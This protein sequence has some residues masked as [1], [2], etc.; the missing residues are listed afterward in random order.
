MTD[1]DRKK[2]KDQQ[3]GEFVPTA[4][5]A[6]ASN[7]VTELH[8]RTFCT[9][10]PYAANDTAAWTK[11]L[12]HTVREVRVRACKVDTTTTIASDNTDYVKFTLTSQYPNG[13][14]I[15]THGAYN[16]HGGAQGALTANVSGSFSLNAAV[17]VV[18]ADAKFR[19]AQ[20]IGGAGKNVV[21]TDTA[22]TLD[23]EE[24]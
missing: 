12:A 16:T 20:S 7:E 13:D 10:R 3:I 19:I 24:I 21:V 4:G 9:S 5:I 14:A 15:A 23:V 1:T 17:A 22:F 8:S 18:P 6:S 2:I 11:Q